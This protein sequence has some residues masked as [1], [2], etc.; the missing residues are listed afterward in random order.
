[1]RGATVCT[2]CLLATVAS[3]ASMPAQASTRSL[4][5]V[6]NEVAGLL[7]HPILRQAEVSVLVVSMESGRVVFSRD[8]QKGLIPASNMKLVLVATA[9]E[10]LGPDWD[11]SALPGARPGET[12]AELSGRILKP[13]DNDIADALMALL[14]AAAGRPELL[15]DQ[16]CAETWGERELFLRVERWPDGSGLSRAALLSAETAVKL[17]R[18]MANGRTRDAWMRALPTSGRDGTLR[19]RMRGTAAEGRVRA[20]T[21]SLTGVSAL[22]GYLVTSSGEQLVFGM[23]FNGFDC[24]L[25]RVRRLQDQ[26][27]AALVTLEREAVFAE[28]QPGH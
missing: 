20:K 17:L 10:L 23:I 12:L 16:L 2:L 8:A 15:P 22:S 13:S 24:E 7:A 4:R 26:L 11:C 19:L 14:P 6:Q 21:G 25:R 18:Y 28:E 27:C 1:M 9:L 5:V 3:L